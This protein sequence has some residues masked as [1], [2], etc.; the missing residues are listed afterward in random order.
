MKLLLSE[1]TNPAVFAT[2]ATAIWPIEPLCP[3]PYVAVTMPFESTAKPLGAPP[4]VLRFARLLPIVFRATELPAIRTMLSKNF[5]SLVSAIFLHKYCLT[6]HS[7]TIK[8]RF[9]AYVSS[10]VLLTTHLSLA[11]RAATF[12]GLYSLSTQQPV[13]SNIQIE[14]GFHWKTLIPRPGSAH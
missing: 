13:H 12:R 6:R 3:L 4:V 14:S 10:C 5:P 8:S 1:A 9:W 7:A 2:V 11:E